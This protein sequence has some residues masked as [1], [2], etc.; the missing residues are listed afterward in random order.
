M[1][2]PAVVS[3]V[4]SGG[5]DSD[6]DCELLGSC[7]DGQCRCSP[8]FS[9]PTCGQLSFAPLPSSTRG[10]VWPRRLDDGDSGTT[11][12]WSLSPIWDP[13]ARLYR[14]VLEVGCGPIW[15]NGMVLA[16]VSSKRPD[17]DFVLDRVIS[18]PWANSPHLLRSA[19]GTFILYFQ[20]SSNNA[21]IPMC[22]GN[23][24]VPAADSPMLQPTM[25]R[26]EPGQSENCLSSGM[27]VATTDDWSKGFQ[28]VNLVDVSGPGWRPYNSTL[29]TIGTSNPTAVQLQDGR[30]LLAFRSHKAYWPSIKPAPGV[31]GEHIGFALSSSYMGP[32]QVVGNLSWQYGNDEDPFVWQQPD[33]TLHCLYHNGRS[34]RTNHGLHAFSRDGVHWHKPAD[35]LSAACTT[36]PANNCSALYT[37]LVHYSDGSV[38]TLTGRERPALLF[39]SEGRPT[40]LYNGIIDSK[41]PW[42]AMAQAISASGRQL[43]V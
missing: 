25:R 32:F 7:V 30:V 1:L 12:S 23:L 18:P 22:T 16:A 10:R 4:V 34:S 29:S 14:A 20:I 43:V 11:M 27:Y 2:L 33:G 24:S 41:L 35:A 28:N 19:N 13:A 38:E 36:S 17:G 8:G 42:Y 37:N 40:H 39:D 3:G 26:C 5:C 6:E 21:S 15:K 9:G 31:N